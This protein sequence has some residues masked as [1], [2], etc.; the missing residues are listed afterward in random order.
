MGYDV[1]YCPSCKDQVCVQGPQCVDLG[2]HSVGVEPTV[3]ARMRALLRGEGLQLR[4][5]RQLL[6]VLLEDHR[7]QLTAID[8]CALFNT[9]DSAEGGRI[10]KDNPY[11]TPAYERVYET[12]KV[13]GNN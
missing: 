8:C 3:E 5:A 4:S 11:W 12:A 6:E 13:R 1:N 7:L 10:T 2:R 9:R